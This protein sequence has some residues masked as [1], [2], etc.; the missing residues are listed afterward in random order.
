MSSP[1]EEGLI[2]QDSE[3]T[4]SFDECGFCL[5]GGCGSISSLSVWGSVS[6]VCGS[7]KKQKK[8]FTYF[9]DIY[10]LQNNDNTK[11]KI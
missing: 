4:S 8:N 10:V 1:L 7:M 2:L 3:G 11:L 5:L 6:S 9:K